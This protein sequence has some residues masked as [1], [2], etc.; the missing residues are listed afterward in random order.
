VKLFNYAL[1][2]TLLHSTKKAMFKKAGL[3]INNDKHNKLSDLTAMSD[4]NDALLRFALRR[5]I[6]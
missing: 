5:Y 1:F 4:W 3:N 2:T 6:L